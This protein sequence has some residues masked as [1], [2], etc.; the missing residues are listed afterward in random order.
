MVFDKESGIPITNAMVNI[1]GLKEIQTELYTSRNGEVHKPLMCVA[2]LK[3]QAHKEGYEPG[4]G[5]ALITKES[6]GQTKVIIEL[7]PKEII[8][9]G[10]DLMININPIYFDFDK[11][12]IRP[13]AAEELDKVVAVM[14]KYPQIII[15]SG[16]HT[17]SRGS[18]KYNIVLS[19]KR[20]QATLDY[21][22]AKGID[23]G[24]IT[25]KGYG[26]KQLTNKCSNGVKC[27]KAGHQ[28]NRRTEFIILNPEVIKK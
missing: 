27:S 21:I 17:D 12:N 3:L 25:G 1:D 2:N 15:E 18:D 23:K 10:E 7:E 16:S 13:D 11:W 6:T 8:A 9:K 5:S 14:Q 28:A 26:E 19:S 4:F 20:A 22:I 24:R